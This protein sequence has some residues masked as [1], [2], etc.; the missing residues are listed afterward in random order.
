V[1]KGNDYASLKEL[2][3]KKVKAILVLGEDAEK[4]EQHFPQK[5]KGKLDS[6]EKAVR[7]A[8]SIAQPNETVLLSPACASFDLFQN[9]ED[10]GRQFK[11]AVHQLN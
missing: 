8:H 1:D 9:Y 7:M 5:V 10:R 6:M 4:F 3:N 2:V 11:A